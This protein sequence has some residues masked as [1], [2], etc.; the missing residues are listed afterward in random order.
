M[1]NSRSLGSTGENVLV[2]IIAI[3]LIVFLLVTIGFENA[4]QW[5][6]SPFVWDDPKGFSIALI[7]KEETTN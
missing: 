7:E 2:A 1:K 5:L 6:F 3:G 4:K